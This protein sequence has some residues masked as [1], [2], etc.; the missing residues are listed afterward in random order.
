MARAHLGDEVEQIGRRDRAHQ[1]KAQRRLLQPDEFLRLALGVLG[2]AE[3]LLEV[4]LERAAQFG[5]VG[6][7]ALAVKQRAA[8]LFFQLLDG[9][10]Q[11][12]LRNVGA[13]RR[14]REVQL[15]A[16]REEVAN[17]MHFHRVA[18][19]CPTGH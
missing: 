7:G 17:L 9:A 11:R 4:W 8:K 12:G 1:P 14:A 19:T 10:G 6:V 3:D 2:A 15:L 16:Q 13:L 5:E 18:R